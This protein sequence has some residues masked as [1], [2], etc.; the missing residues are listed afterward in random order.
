MVFSGHS[1]IFENGM[2]LAEKKPFAAETD[3]I[4]TEAD[5][6]RLRNER[7]RNTSFSGRSGKSCRCVPC[8]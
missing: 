7:H 4:S 8:M 5:L 1:L 3:F 6:F 2:K